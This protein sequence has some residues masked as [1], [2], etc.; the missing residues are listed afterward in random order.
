M[1][2]AG[3]LL[4]APLGLWQARD[5]D[6]AAISPQSWLVLLYYGLGISA[7]A[8]LFWFRGVQQVS[9]SVAGVFTAVLPLSALGISA[10][11]LGTPVTGAHLLGCALVL[12]AIV[13]LSGI[14]LGRAPGTT[15]GTA[16]DPVAA[17]RAPESGR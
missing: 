12:G 16:V 2:L 13:L 10:L 5:V 14:R 4:F 11:V 1:S 15:A 9:G 8:Y 6:L 17:V 3:L 7:A